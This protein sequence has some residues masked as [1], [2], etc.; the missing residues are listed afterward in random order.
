VTVLGHIVAS[1]GPAS[2]AQAEGARLNVAGAGAP[3][4]E[5]LAMRLGGAQHSARPKVSGRTIVVVAG[6]HGAGDPGVA[7][8]ADH[9]TVIAARA[10][11][12]GS[13][14]LVRLSRPTP[15]LLVDAGATES[16]HMP[17]EAVALGRGPSANLMRAPAM[18]VADATLGL[19]AGI[20]LAVSLA[21]QQQTLVAVG[22]I[23][24]G[25]E[26]AAAALL[27]AALG[28]RGIAEAAAD[29]GSVGAGPH[30]AITR[31][32]IAGAA[33]DVTGLGDVGAEA[34]MML[35]AKHAG[36]TGLERLAALGGPDTAVLAG[37]MLGLASM[38]IPVVLDGHATGAAALVAAA[39]APD[40]TGYL[41]AAHGG[42]PLHGRILAALGLEPVFAVGVGHGEGTGAAM[43]LP[44]ADQVAALVS[45]A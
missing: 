39:I 13:A 35:G 8:G 36:D 3:L 45:K 40:V 1:I 38:N 42:S 28:T 5:R 7:M 29:L 6:D 31:L 21:E 4:L 9:P 25:A 19:E 23:G 14:A 34:A 10:I 33:S 15:V 27:G 20:A 24:V 30:K 22:A 44:L 17:D 2:A 26:L 43:V 12:D 11:A 32:P 41:L 16:T 37:L 18:T